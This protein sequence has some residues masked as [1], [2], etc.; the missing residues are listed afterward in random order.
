MLTLERQSQ[1]LEYLK[2]KKVAT[3]E[4][5]AQQFYISPASIR[6]DLNK[7]EKQQLIKRT[8]GGAMLAASLSQ[9]IPAVMRKKEYAV[10]KEYIAAI[11]AKKVR[12]NDIILM[13]ASTTTQQMLP[14]LKER[15]GLTIITNGLQLAAGASDLLDAKIYC[16]GGLVRS[17]SYSLV[18]YQSIDFIR[19]F[20]IQKMF[21][22]CDAVNIGEGIYDASDDE[23]ELR[24]IMIANSEAVYLLC[25]NSKF[26]KKSFYQVCRFSDI[27]YLITEKEPSS[28]WCVQLEHEGVTLLY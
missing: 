5:L 20:H 23:A 10:S 2:Q 24:K 14:F 15:T 19:N 17:N 12:D 26:D 1:I 21:F 13:D 16:C 3:V 7:L 25:D 27:Q 11:A 6:R 4:E 18:G 9:E 22:S 8:Y 28:E